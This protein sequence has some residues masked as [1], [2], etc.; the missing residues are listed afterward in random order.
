MPKTKNLPAFPEPF[1][2]KEDAVKRAKELKQNGY[3]V[4]VLKSKPTEKGKSFYVEPLD[5]MIRTW[6]TVV[7]KS[8]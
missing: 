7:Y 4:C 3:A 2:N 1:E 6:E 5:T 8:E